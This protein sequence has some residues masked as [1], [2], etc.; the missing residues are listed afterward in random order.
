VPNSVPIL[1]R[2]VGLETEYTFRFRSAER[3]TAAPPNHQLYR[4]LMLYLRKQVLTAPARLFKQGVFLANG[5]AVWFELDRPSNGGG[6]LRG[7]TPECRGP[8]EVV[9]YQ[10]A[11][12]QLVSQ[13][14]RLTELNGQLSLFK[15]DRHT[16]SRS[17]AHES[18]EANLGESWQLG[19]WRL[20][21]LFLMPLV[22]ATWLGLGLLIIG[23]LLYLAIAGLVYLPWRWFSTHPQ[24]MAR[25]LFGN[26]FVDGGEMG[27]PTPAWLE[28]VLLWTTRIMHAPLAGC[29]WVLVQTCA[30]RRARQQLLPFLVS[31]G[32]IA[33]AGWLD[34]EGKYVISS[35]APSI[36]GVVGLGGLAHHRSIFTFAHF[37]QA[38]CVESWLSP[39]DYLELLRQR[40]RL[41]I[42]LGDTNIADMAEFLRVGTK[43]L[44]L[45]M[46][47]AGELP[48]LPTLPH[49]VQALKGICADPTLSR[50]VPLADGSEWSGLRLQ[51][52]YLRACQQFLARH[53]DAP[54]EAHEVA[55]AWEEVLD[56]LEQARTAGE[57]PQSLVGSVDWITKRHL[58]EEAG[59][60]VSPGTRRTIDICY[61]ELSPL[62][63]YQMLQ[64]AG[65]A[66]AC[67]S[68]RELERAMRTPP[69]NTPATM[70]GHYIREFSTDSSEL[71]VN[72]SR[73]VLGRGLSSKSIRL[74]R[75]ERPAKSISDPPRLDTHDSGRSNS[76]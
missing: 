41:Q 68:P 64:A 42:G 46:I 65:L 15:L 39:R 11:M 7:A 3:R 60:D 61:H 16:T 59:N 73:V 67:V 44:V 30:F 66:A 2:L 48:E 37:F 28:I 29:L 35:N 75:Y 20:G 51:R 13:S 9:R 6:S 14:A 54:A 38:I 52:W 72:W 45:D 58:L 25:T 32:V 26:D 22:L 8:Q 49:P 10:R 24:K 17:G 21:L 43:T 33:G 1:D 23:I 19:C 63:Y 53:E 50:T 27:R 71:T 70:R 40:Q 76:P 31:R 5:G 36:H 57:V 56:L 47:E 74:A 12:D 4:A 55:A 62:G 69:A 34:N 18:Y